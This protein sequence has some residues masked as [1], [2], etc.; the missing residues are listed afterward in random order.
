MELTM[1]EIF[2]S[3]VM[4][5]FECSTHINYQGR[6]IDVIAATEHDRFAERDYRRLLDIDMKTARD[7]VR[8]HLIEKE[9]YKYDFSSVSNQVRAAR[10]TGIQ[11][12][13]DLFHYGFPIDIDLTSE[14]FV[15]RFAA[16]SGAF[17]KYLTAEGEAIPILCPVNEASFFA[18]MAGEV[19]GFYPFLHNRGDEVKRNLMRAEIAAARTIKTICPQARLVHT[20]PAIHIISEENTPRAVEAAENRSNAQFQALDVLCGKLEPQ[21]GGKPEYLDIVGVNYYFNNQWRFESGRRVFRGDREYR[22]FHKILQEY[23][24]RYRRPIFIAETGIE[25]EERAEWF[26]YICGEMELANNLGAEIQGVCLYP[27]VNHPGWDD[28][29]HCYNGLWDYPDWTGNREIYEPLAAEVRRQIEFRNE[30]EC[31][32]KNQHLLFKTKS[33]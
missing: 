30:N 2:A 33:A 14:E 7:G 1:R 18:W 17:V 9:P 22:P 8:W 6:R 19:G 24:E 3:S 12:V 28:D 11:V 13:W 31:S 16:F 21:L 10:E 26:R 25:N 29:R 23:A 15:E 4:G 32:P 20:D 5:G 27:I